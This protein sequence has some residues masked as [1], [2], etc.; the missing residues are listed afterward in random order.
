MTAAS[1][2]HRRSVSTVESPS[3]PERNVLTSRP[4][5]PAQRL[6]HCCSRLRCAGDPPVEF[7][8]V[9]EPHETGDVPLLSDEVDEAGDPFRLAATTFTAAHFGDEDR[10]FR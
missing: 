8:V 5:R 7:F 9:L 4:P 10:L 1:S 6:R 3:G 2:P